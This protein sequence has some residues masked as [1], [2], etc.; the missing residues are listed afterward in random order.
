MLRGRTF[1]LR[2]MGTL[3]VL[4]VLIGA[5]GSGA[6]RA[7]PKMNPQRTNVVISEFRTS[8][9]A[10]KTDEF[11]EI[12]NPT[13]TNQNLSG[14]ELWEVRYKFTRHKPNFHFSS[15]C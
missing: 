14:W 6:V 3:F 10:G 9:P 15:Q 2:C 4:G 1:F 7:A 5:P 12:F 11:I 8:G 13:T